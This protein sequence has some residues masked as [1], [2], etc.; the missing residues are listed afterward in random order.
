MSV[1]ALAQY[2]A[3]ILIIVVLWRPFGGYMARVFEGQRTWLDPLLC[4][5]ARAMYRVTRVDPQAEM[6]WNEYAAAFILF[7]GVG[8]LLLFLVLRLQRFLAGLAVGVAF[9]RGLAR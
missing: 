2:G 9:I 8:T 3:F 5:V 1:Q 7:S 4:P 6:A